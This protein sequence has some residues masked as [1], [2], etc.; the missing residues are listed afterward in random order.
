[1]VPWHEFSKSTLE[2]ETRGFRNSRGAHRSTPTLPAGVA[3]GI[4]D[5]SV[6]ETHQYPW[7]SPSGS[8]LGSGFTSIGGWI[9]EPGILAVVATLMNP[10]CPAAV[11][12]EHQGNSEAAEHMI[13][14]AA[15]PEPVESLWKASLNMRH[16]WPQKQQRCSK[17]VTMVVTSVTAGTSQAVSHRQL[18]QHEQHEEGTDDA[19]D[20]GSGGQKMQDLKYKQKQLRLKVTKSLLK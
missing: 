15:V 4:C 2:L 6:Q 17:L 12:P 5:L 9:Q 10:A 8:T 20:I 1:M 7:V 3:G 16:R 14:V 11:L 18:K 19:S 13:H